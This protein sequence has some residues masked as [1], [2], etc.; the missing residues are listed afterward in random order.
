MQIGLVTL[1]GVLVALLRSEEGEGGSI[2]DRDVMLTVRLD[3]VPSLCIRD[4]IPLFPT[5]A[6]MAYTGT[7]LSSYMEL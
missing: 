6:C 1:Q 2:I 3:L 5:P 7:N 4:A